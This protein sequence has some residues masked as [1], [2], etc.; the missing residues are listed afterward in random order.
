MWQ[1]RDVDLQICFRLPG[2]ESF[3]REPQ[4][5]LSIQ[6]SHWLCVVGKGLRSSL[7][8]AQ[9]RC[10]PPRAFADTQAAAIV[11]EAPTAIQQNPWQA[12]G[13]AA[14]S[15]PPWITPER[16]VELS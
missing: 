5:G 4:K 9:S 1:L 16:M 10:S 13:C 12:K 8:S 3:D 11:T 6:Q 14:G 7:H 15:E 2:D